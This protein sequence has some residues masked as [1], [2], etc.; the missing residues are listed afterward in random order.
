VEN[1]ETGEVVSLHLDKTTA[2]EVTDVDPAV[3]E[4]VVV[5]YDKDSKHAI[6]FAA[7]A[8]TRN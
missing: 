4:K 8:A 5:E 3:G 7:V 6:S 1:D 2:R